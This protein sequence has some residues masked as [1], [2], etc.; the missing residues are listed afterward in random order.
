MTGRRRFETRKSPDGFTLVELLVVIAII[1]I[2]VGL[3]L[4]AVQ[5]TRA[6]AKKASTINTNPQLQ[7]AAE[8]VLGTLDQLQPIYD[9][10]HR[11]LTPVVD[12]LSPVD[13]PAVRRN[14]DR[15]LVAQEQLQQQIRELKDLRRVTREQ[16]E[17]KLIQDMLK[18]LESLE[19]QNRRDIDLKKFLLEGTSA[20]E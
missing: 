14:L 2:L 16:S 12:S 10:Q 5:A 6:A 19:L 17:R 18:G 7:T 1:A 11:I 15:L 20:D 9:D 13:L 8:H 3:L 4:P